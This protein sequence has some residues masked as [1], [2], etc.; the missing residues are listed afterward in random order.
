MGND[1]LRDAREF[2]RQHAERA[3]RPERDGRYRGPAQ[4]Q[5]RDAAPGARIDEFSSKRPTWGEDLAN[6]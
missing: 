3:T 2:Q 6:R 4:P 1:T 5:P